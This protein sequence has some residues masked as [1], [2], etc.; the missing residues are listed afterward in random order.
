MEGPPRRGDRVRLAAR[1]FPDRIVRRRELPGRRDDVGEWIPGATAD[2]E[3]RASV[4][5]VELTD[6]DLAGG[7]QLVHRLKVFC[8][9]RRERI[10]VA[11]AT[12]LWNGDPLSWNGSPLLWGAGSSVEDAHA[13]AAAFEQA[14][15]DRVVWG[16]VLY[17]VESST[18]WP[19]FTR[20]TLLRET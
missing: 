9:P 8:L 2:F 13:L 3:L 5:P 18:T 11:S 6:S 14:G 20:A 10:S 12:L 4:Q 7:V 15:A 16:G 19:N 1:R 17:V